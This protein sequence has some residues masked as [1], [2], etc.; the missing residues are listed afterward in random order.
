MTPA[1]AASPLRSLAYAVPVALVSY[2]FAMNQVHPK[3]A[4]SALQVVTATPGSEDSRP[5]HTVHSEF[6]FLVLPH[7]VT[8]YQTILMSYGLIMAIAALGFNLL[9]GYTGLLSFGHSAY[10]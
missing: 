10:S 2:D 1:A 8:P 4:W 7:I 6:I 9:L 3:R 5:L